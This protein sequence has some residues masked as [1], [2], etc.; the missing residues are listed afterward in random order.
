M[1][2]YTS[3][4]SR[5]LQPITTDIY[6]FTTPDL[7]PLVRT[8]RGDL[9][10]TINTSFSSPFDIPPLQGLQEQYH[11]MHALDREKFRHSPDLYAVWN[12]KPYFLNAAVKHV[13]K[14][15]DYAF[16]QDAGAFRSDHVYTLWPDPAR[17]EEIWEDGSLLSGAEKEDLLFFPICGVPSWRMRFWTEDMGPIDNEVSE[18]ESMAQQFMAFTSTSSPKAHSLVARRKRSTGGSMCFTLTMTT[19]SPSGFSSAKTRH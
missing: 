5:F 10:I 18:G 9:H 2:D 17:V 3:W 12:A 11:A 14:E 4:L 15:Y 19:T 16:W 13:G 8:V 6:F 1:D 7:E